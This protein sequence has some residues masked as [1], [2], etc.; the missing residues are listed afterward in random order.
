M[1]VAKENPKK[2]NE[3]IYVPMTLPYTRL[4]REGIIENQA[5]K[6]KKLKSIQ[7]M[8]KAGIYATQPKVSDTRI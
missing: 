8:N 3:Y 5:P 2:V 4:I 1:I 7:I 6:R